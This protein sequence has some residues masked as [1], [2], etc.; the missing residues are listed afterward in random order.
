MN[1]YRKFYDAF[2][3]RYAS[4]L[5]KQCIQDQCN[6]RWKELKKQFSG[7]ELKREID[8]KI[9]KL[10]AETKCTQSNLLQFFSQVTR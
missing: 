3:K 8:K 1:D 10:K 5:S 9:S 4:E 7:E 2:S 6:E